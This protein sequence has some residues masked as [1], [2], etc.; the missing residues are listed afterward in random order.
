M[1]LKLTKLQRLYQQQC[2]SFRKS[3]LCAA[4]LKRQW[5]AN[6]S[7]ASKFAVAI[8][9]GRWRRTLRNGYKASA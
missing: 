8:Y 6:A 9:A 4:A 2:P 3:K 5:T 1:S 7:H